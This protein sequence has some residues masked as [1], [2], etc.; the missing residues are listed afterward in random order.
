[1]KDSSEID[2]GWEEIKEGLENQELRERIGKLE[3]ELA[4][5]EKKLAEE[6]DRSWKIFLERTRQ[7]H[8]E[9]EED[10]AR[11]EEEFGRKLQEERRRFKEFKVAFDALQKERDALWRGA[12]KFRTLFD[13]RGQEIERLRQKLKDLEGKKRAIELV[14]DK[15]FPS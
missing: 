4:E 8:A 14:F 12:N 15:E 6:K 3:K 1:M 7:L 11:C 9:H 2:K 10:L 13:E 5:A